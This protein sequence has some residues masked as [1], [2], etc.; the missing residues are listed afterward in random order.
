MLQPPHHVT[1]TTLWRGG[2]DD[3]TTTTT[4]TTTSPP[5]PLVHSMG[6]P[7]HLVGFWYFDNSTK[8]FRN[9]EPKTSQICGEIGYLQCINFS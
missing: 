1:T 5:P 8:F 6:N 9:F 7:P 4:T 2:N 3:T